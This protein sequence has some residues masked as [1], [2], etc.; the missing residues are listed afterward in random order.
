MQSP[1]KN[2][3]IF[4]DF[5]KAC[6]FDLRRLPIHVFICFDETQINS[7][8][9]YLD[10]MI[11]SN[12]PHTHCITSKRVTNGGVHCSLTP[13]QHSSKKCRSNEWAADDTVSDAMDPVIEPTTYRVASDAFNN[14]ANS[15]AY[16]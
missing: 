8:A 4:L 9:K 15:H 10:W 14:Y 1:H 3:E 13:G 11:K 12:F 7:S 6:F 5:L 16:I 2:T